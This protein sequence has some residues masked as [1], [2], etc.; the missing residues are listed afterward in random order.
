M[1]PSVAVGSAA[2]NSASQTSPTPPSAMLTMAGPGVSLM[3]KASN[4]PLLKP[5]RSG[6]NEMSF[7]GARFST[8]TR[9]GTVW[10]NVVEAVADRAAKASRVCV[11][12][13]S[14]RC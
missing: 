1:L 7:A 12:R 10:A 4:V 14:L 3:S 9:T 5:S 2:A 13:M 8:V 6:A 11:W